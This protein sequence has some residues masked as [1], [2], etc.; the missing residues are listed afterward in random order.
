[1]VR[2]PLKEW[3]HKNYISLSLLAFRAKVSS[4]GLSLIE[5]GRRKPSADMLANLYVA[6][7]GEV[8]PTQIVEYGMKCTRSADLAAIRRFKSSKRGTTR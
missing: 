5:R 6:T 1:M 7:E 8:T 4:A 3:R 2:H